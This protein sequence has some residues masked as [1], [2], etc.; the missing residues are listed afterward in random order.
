MPP[1]SNRNTLYSLPFL[2]LAIFF[3]HQPLFSQEN[4]K[5]DTTL[6]K[7]SRGSFFKI[8]ETLNFISKDTLIKLSGAY[9][10]ADSASNKKTIAFYDS[11]KIKASRSMLTKAIYDLVIVSPDTISKRRITGNSQE[12][13]REYSGK[14]IRRIQVQR[15][16]VFGA[17]V[18]NPG[19][20]N[21]KGVEKML[22]STHIN[23]NENILRKYL[24]F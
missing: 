19:L 5:K 24:L 17:D 23:T 1:D 9:V 16:N 22:N 20:Y 6:F 12:S 14:R 4:I 13:F 18:N 21:P 2:F 15:L 3:F 11:L 8:K 7:V 10:T